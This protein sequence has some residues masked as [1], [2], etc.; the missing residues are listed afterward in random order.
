[1]KQTF[2]QLKAAILETLDKTFSDLF[3]KT[4][5]GQEFYATDRLKAFLSHSLDTVMQ[6]S[7]EAVTIKKEKLLNTTWFPALDNLRRTGVNQ[8]I[9]NQ[10][11]QAKAWLANQNKEWYEQLLL[12]LRFWK[13]VRWRNI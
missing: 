7:I 4:T 9:Q 8:A 2:P 6:A 1:M 3:E 13:M 11:E 5:D 12:K 10:H